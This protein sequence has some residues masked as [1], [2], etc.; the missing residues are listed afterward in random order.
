MSTNNLKDVSGLTDGLLNRTSMTPTGPKRTQGSTFGEKVY[1]GVS[2]AGSL[3]A[4][5]ASMVGAV[6]PGVNV[7]STA[8][9]GVTSI[10]GSP[11]GGATATTY[12]ASGVTSLGGGSTTSTVGGTPLMTSGAGSQVG[13]NL[14]AGM[15]SNGVGQYD[16]SLAAMSAQNAQMLQVQM[17]MQRENTM[18]TS[19]SNVLKTKHDTAKNSIGNIR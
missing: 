5:G 11:G 4:H 13:P 6:V 12:A 7:I 3:V 16:T 8:I 15:G 17:V 19:L 2:T 9:G 10:A 18:F 1:A 14:T